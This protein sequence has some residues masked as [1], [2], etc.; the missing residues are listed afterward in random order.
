MK[1]LITIGKFYIQRFIIKLLSKKM[2][3]MKKLLAAVL[4]IGLTASCNKNEE[5]F[6]I[7]KPVYPMGYKQICQDMKVGDMLTLKSIVPAGLCEIWGTYRHYRQETTSCSS[8]YTCPQV[9][10]RHHWLEAQQT[11]DSTFV[12]KVHEPEAGDT[13]TNIDVSIK[14]SHL[15]ESVVT[16]HLIR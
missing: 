11:D 2:T 5:D 4:L 1:I 8:N 16:F 15:G 7:E 13:L 12:F 6:T 10:A 3:F 14:S 9:E